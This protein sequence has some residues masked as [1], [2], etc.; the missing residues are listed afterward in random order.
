MVP[1]V[2]SFVTVE[3]IFRHRHP[4]SGSNRVW[5][6]PFEVHCIQHVFAARNNGDCRWTIFGRRISLGRE[7]ISAA[8]GVAKLFVSV[9][10]LLCKKKRVA[11][12]RL[13]LARIRLR[14]GVIVR[15]KFKSTFFLRDF[16]RGDVPYLSP[17][18]IHHESAAMHLSKGYQTRA[19]NP[20]IRGFLPR[21][22]DSVKKVSNGA[23]F[24]RNHPFFCEFVLAWQ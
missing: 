3:N 20:G 13:C 14:P 2:L 10:Q 17:L 18:K 15:K 5:L 8:P 19:R 24:R 21:S 7:L 16:S 12:E 4:D 9:E 1:L 6:R 11:T 23:W 22:S